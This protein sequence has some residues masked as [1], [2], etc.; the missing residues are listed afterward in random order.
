[1]RLILFFDLPVTTKAERFAY[2]R[3]RKFLLKSGFLM[4]QES[5]YTKLAPN[6]PVLDSIVEHVRKN[7]PEVGLVQMIAVTEKQYS[8]MEIVT[9]EFSTDILNDDRRHVV[10]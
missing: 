6:Q 2:S 1:M 7:R 3:F 4:M 5:V 10:L 8:R 9:G